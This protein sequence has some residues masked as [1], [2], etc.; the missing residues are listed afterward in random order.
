MVF[1]LEMAGRLEEGIGEAFKQTRKLS[2]EL[3]ERDLGSV[4]MELWQYCCLLIPWKMGNILNDQAQESSGQC[5]D[6]VCWPLTSYNKMGDK[7]DIDEETK[8]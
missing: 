2:L 6:H 4:A 7:T 5:V 1:V 8:E 3:E